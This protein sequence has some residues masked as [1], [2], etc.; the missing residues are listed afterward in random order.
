MFLNSQGR[1]MTWDNYDNRLERV[2]RKWFCPA[3]HDSGDRTLKLMAEEIERRGFGS[4]AFRHFFTVQLVLRGVSPAEL[5]RWRGDSS[6]ESAVT[7][8]QNKGEI[9]AAARMAG[10]KL[11][12]S[13]LGITGGNHHE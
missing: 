8:Y 10:A 4:H 9:N 12:E 3:L 5:A 6:L 2:V 7:Y 13:L 1:A 11:T